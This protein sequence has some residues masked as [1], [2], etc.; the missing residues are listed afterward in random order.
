LIPK[1]LAPIGCIAQVIEVID[2]MPRTESKLTYRQFVR[3]DLSVGKRLK[4][5]Y[6]TCIDMV[7]PEKLQVLLDR[8]DRKYPDA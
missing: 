3:D 5:S 4:A 8:L 1:R 7:L 6:D 2:V